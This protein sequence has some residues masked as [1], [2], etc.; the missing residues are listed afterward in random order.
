VVCRPAILQKRCG[1]RIAPV[2]E[3]TFPLHPLPLLW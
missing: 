1:G 2:I 3:G